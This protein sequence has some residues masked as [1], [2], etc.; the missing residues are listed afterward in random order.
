MPCELGLGNSYA[1]RTS[2]TTKGSMQPL[3]HLI[4]SNIIILGDLTF[5]HTVQRPLWLYTHGVRVMRNPADDTDYCGSVL[6]FDESD[7]IAKSLC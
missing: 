2:S 1:R 5:K 6:L 4:F 7:A 3:R